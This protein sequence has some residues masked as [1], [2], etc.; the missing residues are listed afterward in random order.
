MLS[1]KTRGREDERALI[2]MVDSDPI[3][4]NEEKIKPKEE[5]KMIQLGE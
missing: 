4:N 5:T 3:M 2:T 1:C